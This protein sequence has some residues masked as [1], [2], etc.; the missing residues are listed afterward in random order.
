MRAGPGSVL[1]ALGSGRRSLARLR[2]DPAVALVVQAEGNVALT[3][4]GAA[5]VLEDPMPDGVVAVAIDVGSIQ[6]HRRD[7]FTIEA[8]TRFRWTDEAAALRDDEVRDALR[9]I[10]QSWSRG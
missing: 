4:Y 2:A 1:I 3:A 7:A 9:R 8:G 10:A 5:R 6:D